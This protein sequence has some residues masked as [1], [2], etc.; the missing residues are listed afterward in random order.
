M[1]G[2]PSHKER[3]FEKKLLE[4]GL[5]NSKLQSSQ[6]LGSKP[7]KLENKHCHS[8]HTLSL[9]KLNQMINSEPTGKLTMR[10]TAGKHGINDDQAIMR[11]VSE[12]VR[13]F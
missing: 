8:P 3:R 7:G 9:I 5:I 4:E 2:M 10:P 13:A 11:G 1:T 6:A 12:R